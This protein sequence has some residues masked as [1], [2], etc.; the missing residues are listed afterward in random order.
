MNSISLIFIPILIVFV[1][2]YSIK[3][4]NNAYSSFLKGSKE[5]LGLFQEVFPSVLAMLLCV[6]LLGS[7]GIIDDFKL[8]I[9]DIIPGF[10]NFIDIIPMVI[11]RPISGSASIAVLDQICASGPDSFICKMA[12]TI[13]GSTDTT[14]YVL[15]LYFTTV[16]ITKWKH[17]LKVGLLADF[18]GI[19]V[20]IIL[21]LIFF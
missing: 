3:K 12:S 2:I 21:T 15:S 16:G 13:Q 9:S 5:G 7:C 11:F 1:L 19:S 17:A 6:T 10:N 20:G 14:I 4:K 18:I 8:F